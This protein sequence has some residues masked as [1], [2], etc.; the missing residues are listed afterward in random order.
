MDVLP[1]YDLIQGIEKYAN[2]V[3][4][5]IC[6]LPFPSFN[7][8]H[9]AVYEAGMAAFR[10]RDHQTTDV[11]V[12]EYPQA[13]WYLYD[14]PFVPNMYLNIHASIEQK[15]NCFQMYLSQQ[16]SENYAISVD[17]IYSLAKL[18]GKEVSVDYA[19]AYMIKRGVES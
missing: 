15:A 6:A 9:K 19:E 16:K 11:L 14:P 7:Q 1:C 3:R 8:D 17:G 18:R 4:P 13:G 5:D 12:Y 2:S 10:S